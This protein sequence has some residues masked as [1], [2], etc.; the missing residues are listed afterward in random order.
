MNRTFLR[1]PATREALAE[2][3]FCRNFRH[4][5]KRTVGLISEHARHSG[6]HSDMSGAK[7]GQ[8]WLIPAAELGIPGRHLLVHVAD[9]AKPDKYVLLTSALCRK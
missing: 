7:S 3:I 5:L 8:I 6:M 9:V 1:F 2:Y 4:R